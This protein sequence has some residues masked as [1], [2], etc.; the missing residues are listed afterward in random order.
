MTSKKA[1]IYG[2][3]GFANYLCNFLNEQNIEIIG[4][5]T[6]NYFKLGD[7][8]GGLELYKNNSYPVFIGVFNHKD[9]PVEILDYLEGIKI[10]EIFTPAQ[11]CINF[12]DTEF[13]K[14]YLS[15]ELNKFHSDYDLTNVIRTQEIEP[16]FYETSAFY[17]F[18]KEI[19][20]K[21]NRRIGF[22]PFLVETDRIESI[23]ID[24]KE[25]Y[26]LAKNIINDKI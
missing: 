23:D 10:D 14:Y 25:D 24:E 4:T 7:T 18:K 2:A 13:N 20:D 1:W 16:V 17:I 11:I 5:I 15:A 21:S 6:K 8:T 12:P 26:E 3:G 9:D 19:L 22:N